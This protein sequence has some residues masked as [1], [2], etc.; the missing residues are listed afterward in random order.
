MSRDKS[1]DLLF[2]KGKSLEI[3]TIKYGHQRLFLISLHGHKEMLLING[4]H[5]YMFVWPITKKVS[6]YF[7]SLIGTITRPLFYL[8]CFPNI[9]DFLDFFSFLQKANKNLDIQGF[10]YNAHGDEKQWYET[11]LIWN[12]LECLGDTYQILQACNKGG[13]P[14]SG[15]VTI[16]KGPLI[17]RFIWLSFFWRQWYFEGH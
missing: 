17:D 7:F 6:H 9:P 5:T 14:Y 16:L 12:K 3:I 4:F 15:R 13:I 2:Y 10:K 11:K 8:I 1:L